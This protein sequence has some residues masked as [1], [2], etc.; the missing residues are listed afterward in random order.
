MTSGQKILCQ[1]IF[2]HPL[3]LVV[4]LPNQ[5]TGH[6]PITQI[7]SVLSEL[8]E[9]D[10]NEENNA[11]N[12]DREDS[13][14]C[15][16]DDDGDMGE[17]GRRLK[18]LPAMSQMFSIGQYLPAIVTEVR[19]TGRRTSSADGSLDL[20][21]KIQDKS[22]QGCERIQLSVSPDKVNANVSS[23]AIIAG[24][25][26]VSLITVHLSLVTYRL[27]SQLISGMVKSVEDHGYVFDFGIRPLS[28]FLPEKEARKAALSRSF[29]LTSQPK[30]RGE[31]HKGQVLFVR[32]LSVAENGRVATISLSSLESSIVLDELSG[33]SSITPGALV[34]GSVTAIDPRGL[35]LKLGGT[36]HGTV[37]LSHIKLPSA[38]KNLNTAFK[39]GDKVSFASCMSIDFILTVSL[40][41]STY[42]VRCID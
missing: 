31:L 14:A 13:E 29:S 1:I 39:L 32:I 17:L 4:S 27:S 24:S 15:H 28:G 5:L 30:K 8:I 37:D 12:V 6:I 26:I 35:V 21:S 36:S 34:S 7:S 18:E 33:V 40:G 11:M 9:N 42:P 19:K 25:V 22:L 2:I 3:A 41:E 10:Q 23:R 38:A 16:E 20:L